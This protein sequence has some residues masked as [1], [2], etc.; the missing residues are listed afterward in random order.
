MEKW[1]NTLS[2]QC[3]RYQWI[4]ESTFHCYYI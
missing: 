2:R 4:Q 3:L 1:F